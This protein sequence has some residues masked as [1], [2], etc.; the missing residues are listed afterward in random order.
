MDAVARRRWLGA[1]ALV[2]A[3]GMLLVGHLGL[4]LGAFG[5]LIYWLACLG[6]TLLAIGVAL[7]DAQ[8]VRRHLREERRELLQSTLQNIQSE[9]Q[10]RG[11][12]PAG[13]DRE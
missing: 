11:R 2:A 3:L 9:A 5:W 6:C 12:P 7:W 13:G 10:K 8:A 1:L 4:R